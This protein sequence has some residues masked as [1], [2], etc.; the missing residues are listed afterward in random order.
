MERM[1]DSKNKRNSVK[2]NK[3]KFD[4]DALCSLFRKFYVLKYMPQIYGSQ[5]N[6]SIPL[7]TQ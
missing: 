2:R 1:H 7:I 3:V 6:P 4:H 5:M